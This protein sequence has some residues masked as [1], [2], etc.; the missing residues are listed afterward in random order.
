MNIDF[1]EIR[2]KPNTANTSVTSRQ[3]LTEN[4]QS[5]NSLTSVLTTVLNNQ[6]IDNN[7]N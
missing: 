7:N 5:I 4:F 6:T 3:P 1:L 2:N